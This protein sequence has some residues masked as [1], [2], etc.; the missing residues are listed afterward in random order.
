MSISRRVFASSCGLAVTASL[1]SQE[2]PTKPDATAPAA[3]PVEAPFT[4]DYNAP[5]FQPSWKKPQLN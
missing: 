1:L 5:K 4:R 3:G 2:P